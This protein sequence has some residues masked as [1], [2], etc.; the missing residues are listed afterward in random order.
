MLGFLPFPS[1]D[2]N[3][4]PPLIIL[5]PIANYSS[6]HSLNRPN[7]SL[8][9]FDPAHSSFN[10]DPTYNTYNRSVQYSTDPPLR[11]FCFFSR[12]KV[13]KIPRTPAYIPAKQ[14]QR[15][16]ASSPNVR[17]Y[18]AIHEK[19]AARK[20]CSSM[21][22]NPCLRPNAPVHINIAAGTRFPLFPLSE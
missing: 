19:A 21:Q 12:V 11:A 6:P 9:P 22:Y 1:D 14:R 16:T 2:L 20:A 4:Q 3:A 17:L 18:T 8:F 13:L 15:Y 10:K 7:P 5:I